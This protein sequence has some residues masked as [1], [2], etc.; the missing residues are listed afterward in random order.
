MQVTVKM[1]KVDVRCKAMDQ[2][3]QRV[4]EKTH[5][6]KTSPPPP[7]STYPLARLGTAKYSRVGQVECVIPC[8]NRGFPLMA[9]EA[10]S[11]YVKPAHFSV[12]NLGKVKTHMGFWADISLTEYKEISKYL[13]EICFL[14]LQELCMTSVCDNSADKV[15]KA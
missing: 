2:G 6:S 4:H 15:S 10:K 11:C 8:Q 13:Q 14:E 12:K 3:R 7:F 9:Q 1:W 5:G